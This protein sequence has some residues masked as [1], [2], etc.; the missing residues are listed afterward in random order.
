MSAGL[1]TGRVYRNQKYSNFAI[2]HFYAFMRTSR[3]K[4]INVWR[5][6]G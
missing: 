6:L 1:D 5:R 3:Q 2:T 4:Y